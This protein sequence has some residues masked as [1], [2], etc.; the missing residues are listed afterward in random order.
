[1]KR[2]VISRLAVMSVRVVF[3]LCFQTLDSHEHSLLI[4]ESICYCHFKEI[5]YLHVC[6]FCL[7]TAFTV[8]KHV[9]CTL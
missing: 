6:W 4:E 9:L 3:R 8:I 2:H 5:A 1:M 7:I